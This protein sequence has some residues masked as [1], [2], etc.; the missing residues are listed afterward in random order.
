MKRYIKEGVVRTRKTIVLKEEINGETY[1]VYLPSEEKILAAGWA[2]YE[3]EVVEPSSEELYKV[4]IIDLIRERYSTDDEIALLR[5]RDSKPEE[6]AEY[7]TYVENCK[8]AAYN[9]VYGG[10]E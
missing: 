9:E 6:F 3:S 7:N 5:Q 4:R 2:P 1:D 10:A 8:A